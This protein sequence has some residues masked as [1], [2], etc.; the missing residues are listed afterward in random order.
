MLAVY[1]IGCHILLPGIDAA[2]MSKQKDS[3]G[4]FAMIAGGGQMSIRA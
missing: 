3:I 1:R 2:E 4:I